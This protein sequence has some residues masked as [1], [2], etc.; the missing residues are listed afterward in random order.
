MSNPVSIELKDILAAIE[1]R[2]DSIQV[3][4]KELLREINTL[5]ADNQAKEKRLDSIQADQ[6]ELLREINNMKVDMATLKTQTQ[7]TQDFQGTQRTQLWAIITLLG[8]TVISPLFK[9]LIKF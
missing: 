4:Q 2:L 3:D 5:K 6:K 9:L 7:A 1:K 8:I